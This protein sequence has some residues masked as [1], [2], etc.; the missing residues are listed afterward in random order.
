M[1]SLTGGRRLLVIASQCE[2]LG[3]QKRLPFLPGAAEELYRVM[4][5]P[6][7]GQ[8]ASA[9]PHGG[10]LI[11]PTVVDVRAAISEAFRLASHEQA[12][13]ILAYIGHGCSMGPQFYLLPRDAGFPP[14]SDTAVNITQLIDELYLTS[15]ATIDGLVLLL[16]TCYSGV[17]ASAA[18]GGWTK[19]TARSRRFEVLAASGD[20]PAY[21]GCFTRSLTVC[22]RDGIDDEPSDYLRCEHA[23]KI[24]RNTC[25]RQEPRHPTNDA[26]QGLFLARNTARNRAPW[27]GTGAAEEVARLT[28]D[29]QPT[30]M[31]EV[32]MSASQRHRGV[33]MI[34]VA[35]SGKSTL[36]AAVVRPEIGE[37]FVPANFAH[38]VAFLRNGL[39]SNDV[40]D[41]L[42]AQ[43]SRTVP[44]FATAH[45][46][47]LR[48]LTHEER[49]RLDS[50]HRHLIGP[51]RRL[52]PTDG[53]VVRIVV[54]GLERASP[55]EEAFLRDGLSELSDGPG[56]EHVRLIVSAQVGTDLPR[57][58]HEQQIQK[59]D[60]SV[61]L[62]YLGRRGVESA[63]HDAILERA[64]RSWL[65]A[66]A[67]ADLALT[68]PTQA[69]AVLPASL[70][71]IYA[72]Y[73]RRA[74]ASNREQWRRV[75]RPVLAVMAAAG[76]GAILPIRL[77]SAASGCL[78]GPDRPYQ[79]RD[80]L[81]DLRGLVVRDR[82][83]TDDE[84]VGLFHSTLAAYLLDPGSGP[85]GI[86]PYD[87]HRAV[88]DSL[89]ELAPAEALAELTPAQIHELGDPVHRYAAIREPDHLW[90]VGS[91]FR[92]LDSLFYRRSVIPAE[93][94]ERN[95]S[96]LARLK[97]HLGDDHEETLRMRH[98]IAAFTAAAGDPHEGVRQLHVLY[99]DEQR[100]L[101]PGHP[102]TI[103]TVLSIAGWSGEAGISVGRCDSSVISCYS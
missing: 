45:D 27:A 103:E 97:E 26:D 47:Y 87:P 44:G 33:A 21:D 100:L 37:G 51:L 85:F 30:P 4:L 46:A 40:A 43:L 61:L 60:R 81:V 15:D 36:A 50:I 74:G 55:A 76:A 59:P 9:L 49:L 3:D 94:L 96:W 35:G 57:A 80:T 28:V 101:G 73:L 24:I 10:L 70:T 39:S 25:S 62:A 75:L 53:S 71:E 98:N 91:P 72:E 41:M 16:D 19:D 17:G 11:D 52:R 93:N 89:N 38:A 2:A 8:C 82:P 54:D 95:R 67:L 83:G 69:Q 6:E 12:T 64:D 90:A 18:A 20:R 22:L 65:V 1:S 102:Y 31:L 7:R 14:R 29:F 86:D 13:L 99:R 34:G 79:I 92:L 42:R 78:G 84:H 68:S 32:V 77:L 5:D 63:L 88:V 56:L 23:Q 48:G 66:S 58:C